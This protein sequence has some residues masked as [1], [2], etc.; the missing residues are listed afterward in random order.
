[1][2]I[3]SVIKSIIGI[4]LICGLSAAAVKFAPDVSAPK[5]RGISVAEANQVFAKIHNELNA[6]G[7]TIQF[8]IDLSDQ[9]IN[10]YATDNEKGHIIVILKGMLDL[11]ESKDELAMVIGHELAHHMLSHV[12]IEQYTIPNPVSGKHPDFFK[13]VYFEAM[14]DITGAQ[15]AAMAGY[16]PCAG[17]TLWGKMKSDGGSTHPASKYRQAVF[18]QICEGNAKSWL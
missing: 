8:F 5:K 9:S 4:S 10:A 7:K 11:V 15:L 13:G 17:V 14:A 6:E 12:E 3:K 2:P 18:Q 1:M 16:D